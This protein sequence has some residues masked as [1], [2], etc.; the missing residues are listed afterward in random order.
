MT[1][2]WK[3]GSD[4]SL[5]ESSLLELY[6]RMEEKNLLDVFFYNGDVPDV[7]QFTMKI[8]NECSSRISWFLSAYRDRDFND[9]LGFA[10]LNNAIGHNMLC[11]FCFFNLDDRELNMRLADEFHKIVFSTG[12]KTLIGITPKPFRHAW[13]F[14]LDVGF[15]KIMELPEACYIAKHKRWVPAIITI[16]ESD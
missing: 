16:K 15:K 6:N 9:P 4:R 7:F 14:A 3:S 1:F 13:K 11:H 12:L 2:Y 8:L 5:E 10:Y